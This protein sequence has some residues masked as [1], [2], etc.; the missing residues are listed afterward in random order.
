MVVWSTRRSCR[1][2]DRVEL[3]HKTGLVVT[4]LESR[5][6]KTHPRCHPTPE[7]FSP[8]SNTLLIYSLSY[9]RF[10]YWR[11]PYL[12]P[13]PEV[14]KSSIANRNGEQ[15]SRCTY[16]PNGSSSLRVRKQ[17]AKRPSFLCRF[18]ASNG[19]MFQVWLGPVIAFPNPS[20]NLKHGKE[21][22]F[23]YIFVF[24]PSQRFLHYSTSFRFIIQASLE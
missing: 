19:D 7:H 10:G 6:I 24:L 9:P 13:Y 23:I 15:H 21:G 1:Q 3:Q 20:A 18:Y 14:Q 2:L 16:F 22:S 11:L 5:D 17:L 8:R 4:R 12:L